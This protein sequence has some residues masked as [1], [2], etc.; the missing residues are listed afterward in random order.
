MRQILSL[1]H[2]VIDKVVQLCRNML[3]PIKKGEAFTSPFLSQLAFHFPV[4]P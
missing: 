1:E 4:D 2:D 3:W